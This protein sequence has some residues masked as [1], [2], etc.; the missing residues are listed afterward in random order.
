MKLQNV[1]LKAL[2]VGAACLLGSTAMATAMAAVRQTE[3]NIVVELVFTANHAH[4]DP[5]NE[6]TL[7]VVFADPKGHNLRVPAF[8]AGRNV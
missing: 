8:W 5:F 4:A 6:V 3:T 7:D 2:L 1:I